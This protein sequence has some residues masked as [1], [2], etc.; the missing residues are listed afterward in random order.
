MIKMF[1]R[2]LRRYLRACA[3]SL[4]TCSRCRCCSC[5]WPK[6]NRIQN[7]SWRLQPRA[8]RVGADGL[9]LGDP[10]TASSTAR[11]VAAFKLHRAVLAV[12]GDVDELSY[13][14]A[15]IANRASATTD[16]PRCHHR[17]TPI[18]GCSPRWVGKESDGSTVPA[19]C[20]PTIWRREPWHTRR[21]R[22]SWPVVLSATSLASSHGFG[23]RTMALEGKRKR[24]GRVKRNLGCVCGHNTKLILL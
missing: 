14:R 6:Q 11:R 15:A 21:I 17:R 23:S 13:F 1:R 7:S 5:H 9:E 2:Y 18:F 20:W 8:A 24:C 16:A 4:A 12:G 10:P 3:G 22:L 19:W